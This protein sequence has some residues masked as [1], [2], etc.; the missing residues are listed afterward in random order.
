M[1][2]SAYNQIDELTENP[3]GRINLLILAAAKLAPDLMSGFLK[4]YPQIRV[5]L[6]QWLY[7]NLRYS[8]EFD[9]SISATPMDYSQ[10][11]HVPLL[12]EEI[13]LVVASTHPLAKMKLIDLQLAEPYEFIVISPGPSIRTLTDNLCYLAG[14]TPRIRCECDNMETMLSMIR[15]GSCVALLAQDTLL[16]Y[17]K[18][19]M[20][21]LSLSNSGAR[22]TVNL[23]WRKD[24]Y[25]SKACSLF[26][27]YCIAYFR[28]RFGTPEAA[29]HTTLPGARMKPPPREP[30]GIQRPPPDQTAGPSGGR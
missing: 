2:D 1:I 28:D 14:F 10:H 16:N 19:G 23:A 7:Y 27:D 21:A 6:R 5:N 4:K 11:E 25:L 9:F 18:S 26:K 29:V 24:K 15:D 17:H 12:T 20:T 8:E 13:V 30:G 3:Y 22:R